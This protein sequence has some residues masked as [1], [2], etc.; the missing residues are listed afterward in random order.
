MKVVEEN[1]ESITTSELKIL[2]R[3][4][5]IIIHGQCLIMKPRRVSYKSDM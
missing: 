1:I 5:S 4:A 3:S 2:E